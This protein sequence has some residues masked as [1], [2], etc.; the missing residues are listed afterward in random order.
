[1]ISGGAAPQTAKTTVSSTQEIHGENLNYVYLKANFS[2]FTPNFSKILVNV[3]T[4]DQ[5][6]ASV[7]DSSSFFDLR[8]VDKNGK[9]LAE[10]GRV[11]TNFKNAEYTTKTFT[12]NRNDQQLGEFLHGENTLQLV[13][14]SEYPGWMN[15]V[16]FGEFKFE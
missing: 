1:M 4:R 6:W 9:L 15:Y 8:V 14:R 11:I 16:K 10:K 3:S 2:D 7:Q 13:V 12:L 5:G